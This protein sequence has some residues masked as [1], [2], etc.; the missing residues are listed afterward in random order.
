MERFL[1]GNSERTANMYVN[2]NLDRNNNLNSSRR[3]KKMHPFFFVGGKSLPMKLAALHLS[4][5]DFKGNFFQAINGWEFG[6]FALQVLKS[7]EL[8]KLLPVGPA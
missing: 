5:Q 3:G 7:G 2:F 8:F 4:N 1:R 6:E